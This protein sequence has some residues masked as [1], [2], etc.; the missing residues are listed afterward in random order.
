MKIE[1]KVLWIEDHFDA[2]EAHIE[3]L[4]AKLKDFGFKLHVDRRTTLNN[5]K[6]EELSFKLS[7]YNPYDIIIFDYDLEGKM[8]DEIAHRLRSDIFT[9]MIFYSGVPGVKLREILFKKEVDGVYI[10][11]RS[12]FID[13]VLPIIE[14]Q[15][16]RICDINNMRGVILDEMSRIDL[17]MRN[18]YKKKYD[19]LLPEEQGQQ[20][21]KFKAKLSERITA[22]TKQVEDIVVEYFSTMIP[23]PIKVEFN[24]VRSRLKS[25]TSN[26]AVFGENS[27]LKLKQDLRNKFAHNTAKYDDEEGTV[28]LE[29]HE[30]KYGFSE[31]TEIRKDLLKLSK[32]LDDVV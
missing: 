7:R 18:M 24:I 26:D 21:T 10:V 11:N 8:G 12:N 19:G 4:E 14:D 28:A 22:I 16:K 5:V 23:D 1:Y 2:V 25:V 31:F 13:E 9:D 30:E 3:G 20:L 17:K 29:G 6:L 32:E 15:I 27:A